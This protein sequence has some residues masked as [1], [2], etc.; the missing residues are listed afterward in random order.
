M[1]P[2]AHIVHR[3]RGRLRLKVPERCRDV[4]WFAEAASRLEQVPGVKQVAVRAV[5]GSLLIRHQTDAGLEE[6]LAAAG[7]GSVF[8]V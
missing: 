1:L 4:D 7:Q 2:T 3:L 5:S 8:R 6:R